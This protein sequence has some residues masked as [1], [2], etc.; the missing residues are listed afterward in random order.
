[1]EQNHKA[2]QNPPRVV[3][4]TEEEE[5]IR[6]HLLVLFKK[7]YTTARNSPTFSAHCKIDSVVCNFFSWHYWSLFL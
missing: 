3:A 7:F 6:G 2:G 1:V 4:P 5:E